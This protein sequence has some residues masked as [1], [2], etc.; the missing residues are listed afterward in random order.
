MKLKALTYGDRALGEDGELIPETV[1]VEMT[2]E[3]AAAILDVAGNVL[4]PGQQTSTGIYSTLVVVIN[5][6]FYNGIV[7]A[8]KLLGIDR[9]EFNPGTRDYHV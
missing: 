8:R 4:G 6:H 9:W 3:E 2:I 1:T 5:Q 7:D